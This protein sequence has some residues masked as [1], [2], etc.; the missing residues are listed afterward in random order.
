MKKLTQKERIKRWLISG[1]TISS[2]QAFNKFG[3]TRLAARC[4]ELRQLG[5]N[6]KTKRIHKKG[7]H[8]D[9]YFID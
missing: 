9:I 5:F 6:I 7:T 4:F 1:K 2:F 3:I 8:Y